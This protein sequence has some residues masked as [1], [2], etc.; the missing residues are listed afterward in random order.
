LGRTEESDQGLG[1]LEEGAGVDGIVVG[2]VN[3]YVREGLLEAREE[4]YPRGHLEEIDYVQTGSLRAGGTGIS[5]H[6]TV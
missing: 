3:W 5:K 2:R 4:A 6:E 1:G